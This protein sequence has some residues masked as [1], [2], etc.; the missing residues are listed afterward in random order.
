MMED[1]DHSQ[2]WL[3]TKH[4]DIDPFKHSID[5]ENTIMTNLAQNDS[6]S[7]NSNHS[8]KPL[9]LHHTLT[10]FTQSAFLTPMKTENN[11]H[12]SQFDMMNNRVFNHTNLRSMPKRIIC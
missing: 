1:S 10:I 9:L 8:S 12:L 5:D 7:N 3:N 2:S 4:V 6:S 11:A